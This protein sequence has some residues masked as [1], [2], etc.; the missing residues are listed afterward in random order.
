[1]IFVIGF[2]TAA[3]VPHSHENCYKNAELLE[4]TIKLKIMVFETKEFQRID[5]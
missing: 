4:A 2:V 5:P 1:M 3:T